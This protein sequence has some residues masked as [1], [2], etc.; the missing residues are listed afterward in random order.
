MRR[1]SLSL[2]W[3]SSVVVI[4]MGVFRYYGINLSRLQ[5]SEAYQ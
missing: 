2:E 1:F 5:P 3:V 4:I